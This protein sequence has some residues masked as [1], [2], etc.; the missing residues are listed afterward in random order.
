MMPCCDDVIMRTI[1]EIPPA[2]LE[3]LDRHCQLEGISRA[4]AVRRALD[5]HLARQPSPTTR[6]SAFPG[7]SLH[8]SASPGAVRRATLSAE[9]IR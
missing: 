2:Q 9:G 8:P 1:V 6:G 7:D 4:E 3:R 5:A